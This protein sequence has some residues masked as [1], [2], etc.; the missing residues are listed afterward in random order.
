MFNPEHLF[1]RHGDGISISTKS[2]HDRE[3]EH[4]IAADN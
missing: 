2:N 4:K 3:I 1:H